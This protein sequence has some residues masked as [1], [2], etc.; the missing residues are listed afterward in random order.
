MD[1]YFGFPLYMIVSCKD[2]ANFLSS[3]TYVILRNNNDGIILT[4]IDAS[5]EIATILDILF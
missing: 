1:R 5:T 2:K 4:A 3:S